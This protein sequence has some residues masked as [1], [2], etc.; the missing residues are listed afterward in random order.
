VINPGAIALLAF[1][2]GDYFS[3]VVPLGEYS[4]AIWALSIVLLL[5]SGIVALLM[6]RWRESVLCQLAQ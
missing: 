3:Q 5:G 1:V 6:L 2:F 4:S